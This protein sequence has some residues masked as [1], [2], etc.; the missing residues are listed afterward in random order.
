MQPYAAIFASPVAH[1]RAPLTVKNPLC[2]QIT[3][4]DTK[5]V[6]RID[7]AYPEFFQVGAQGLMDAIHQKGVSSLSCP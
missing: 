3:D 2:P 1:E 6:I 5:Q 7:D 4:A